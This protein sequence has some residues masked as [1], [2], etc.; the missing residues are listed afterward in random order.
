LQF[1]PEFQPGTL[2]GW[3]IGLVGLSVFTAAEMQG[4]SPRM[5]GEQA[6][7]IIEGFVFAALGLL[8]WIV[9]MLAG[10]R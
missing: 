2:F 8:Y 1:A 9:P 4:M 7:W 5:R 10:W 3:G 6:N